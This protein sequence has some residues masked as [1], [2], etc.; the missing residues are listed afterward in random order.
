M[1]LLQTY[2]EFE[3]TNTDLTVDHFG[4]E[5]CA[6]HYAFGPTIRDNYVLHFIVEGKGKFHIDETIWELQAGD[7]FL[8]SKDKM[9]FYRADKQEPWAYLW[10]GFSGNKADYFLN[11][12]QITE[13]YICHSTLDSKVL[14]QLYKIMRFSKQTSTIT[15][16][17]EITGELFRLLAYLIEEQ[18]KKHSLSHN[19]T[20]Q[21]YTKQALRIIHN[22]YDSHLQ[23]NE[24]AK[25]LNLSRSYL[26]KLFKEQTGYA[27]KDYILK[28]KLEKSQQL[29]ANPRFS[30]TEIASMVGF[31]DSLAFSKRFKKQYGQSP[32]QYR[33]QLSETTEKTST[34]TIPSD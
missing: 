22:H 25:E 16:E 8:L 32:S 20:Q 14:N 10:V 7:M 1:N 15:T 13:H 12:S 18:P 21:H 19:I 17:L 31:T 6:S 2:N 29:L 30:I 27:L 26:Y 5:M 9:T 33:R 11:Q 24:I 4:A 3:F 23:V 34:E 28:V